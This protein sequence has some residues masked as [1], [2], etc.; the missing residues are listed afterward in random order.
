M[1]REEK[2]SKEQ[3]EYLK[4]LCDTD[5]ALA[6]ARQLTQEFAEMVRRLEGE[7]LDAWLEEAEA[8]TA[9]AMKRF[10]LGLKKDLDAVRAGLIERWST[11]S[12]C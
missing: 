11:S 3:K 2:L 6:D 12:S 10:A 8:C 4:M 5:A 7:K 1:R 9:P